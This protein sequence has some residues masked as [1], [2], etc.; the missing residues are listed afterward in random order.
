MAS[1]STM[2]TDRWESSQRE[3]LLYL[4]I[5]LLEGLG[6]LAL[7]RC[8]RAEEAAVLTGI[9]DLNLQK[10][11]KERTCNKNAVWWEGDREYQFVLTKEER[12]LISSL[13]R[14]KGQHMLISAR[15]LSGELYRD[16]LCR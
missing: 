12:K 16:L 15:L 2:H 11:T 8:V 6:L 4:S 14:E 9:S 3:A 7:L 13:R 5:C 1:V 10:K